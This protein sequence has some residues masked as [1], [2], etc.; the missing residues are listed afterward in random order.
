MMSLAADPKGG[1]VDGSQEEDRLV[2]SR[3]GDTL[4][5][6][7]GRDTLLGGAGDDSLDGG[8]DNDFLNGGT[9]ADTMAGGRGSDTFVV[10]ST[11]DF[12]IEKEGEGSDTVQTTL[13]EFALGDFVENLRFTGK[14]HARLAGNDADND[15]RGGTDAD[16]LVGNAGNDTIDGGA[17]ADLMSGGEGA[18]TF[19]VD[20]FGDR[21]L[22][23]D[24]SDRVI[25]SIAGYDHSL[26]GT[27]N[28]LW[29]LKGT[30]GDD[31]LAGW[32]GRDTLDGGTGK[33]TLAGAAGD[34]LYR[35]DHA[36]DAVLEEMSGGVDT[37]QTALAVF[38]LPDNVE[39]FVFTGIAVFADGNRLANVMSGGRGDD[40]LRG[41]GGN[42]TLN[43]G[44]GDDSL[45]GGA[46]SD[47]LDG[48]TGADTLRGG[49]GADV[50]V[51]DETRDV[52][53]AEAGDTVILKVAG[54]DLSKLGGAT[55]RYALTGLAGGQ[56]LVGGNE[57]DTLDGD[58]DADTMQGGAGD[59]VYFVD[60]R[61]DVVIEKDGEGVDTVR[62]NLS[63]YVL[64]SNVERLVA[65]GGDAF[66][67]IGNALHNSLS[68]GSG[69]DWLGGREGDD[70]LVGGGGA[71]TLEGEFGADRLIGG[72]GADV[73]V[74][75]ASDS[76][77]RAG[78]RDLIT[79]FT[80]GADVLDFRGIRAANGGGLSWL[81]D[82]L[83]EG[84]A[85]IAYDART[86]LLSVDWSSDA[87]ADMQIQLTR[88]LAI[89][90]RDFVF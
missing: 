32:D 50:Y 69:R 45:L 87:R 42:D 26:S 25:L 18:D 24:R 71:D 70:T 14:G 15:L 51:V 1:R 53:D 12:V 62:T 75:R 74:F 40:V 10:D 39:R 54:Y 30:A 41:R 29:N 19:I 67:G 36:G 4:F 88:S 55:V 66:L 5:A 52:V 78:S 61:F 90:A 58:L 56:V 57:A 82:T 68:G 77:T 3:F 33:D 72:A 89:S 48:G 20:D 31:S 86:G 7:T 47:R 38:A 23:G 65:L 84:V 8:A 21:I 85:G 11:G 63:S 76:G 59:D 49:G 2:G 83:R 22:D 60:D 17:G 44:G 73:F 46:D 34:D 28:V 35:V 80:V 6:S 16:T 9:G 64:G 13:V 79:D 81:G 37:I 27:D 43:G